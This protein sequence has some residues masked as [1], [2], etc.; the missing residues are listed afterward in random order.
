MSETKV[1]GEMPKSLLS[2]DP[3][4]ATNGIFFCQVLSAISLGA[5][6]F[7]CVLQLEHKLIQLP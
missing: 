6:P 2:Q 7:L 5:K 1:N 4:W 3:Y